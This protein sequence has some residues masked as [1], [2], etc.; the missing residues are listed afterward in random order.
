MNGSGRNKEPTLSPASFVM[1]L[2]LIAAA[3]ILVL[4]AL[5]T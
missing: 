1:I 4:L 2:G 5:G 3:A